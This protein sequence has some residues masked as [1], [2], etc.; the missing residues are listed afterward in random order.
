MTDVMNASG[1]APGP[2]A[3]LLAVSDLHVAMA[4]NRAIV[5][6]LRPGHPED[7]LLVAG[8]VAELGADFE[9]AMTTLASRFARVVWAPGN[10]ELWT[11][12]ADPVQ[13]R[14]DQRYRHL[15]DVCRRLGV[16]TPEDPFPVWTGRGGP[17]VVAPLFVLY[18][19]SF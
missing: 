11:H 7:W 5:E 10:H 13:L 2:G 4:E 12:P 15:T 17:V 16:N 14:G 18:D 19:Y 8:D 3:C 9:W 1:A 6:C